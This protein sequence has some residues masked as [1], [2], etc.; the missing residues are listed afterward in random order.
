MRQLIF[1]FCILF[2]GL[3]SGYA[4]KLLHEKKQLAL[5]CSIT[6]LRILLQKTGLIGFLAGSFFLALWVVKLPDVRLSAMPFLCLCALFFGGAL[7]YLAARV[8]H[9]P[10]RQTGALYCC[11]AFTNIGAIGSLICYVFLGE[12]GF[13]L[14][15]VY[16][17]FE[18]LYYFTIGFSTA[19]SFSPDGASSRNLAA[20]IRQVLT[21]P[22]VI[23][24]L[25]A[26]G[27]GT[28]LNMLGVPRPAWCSL[29]TSV[30]V[31]AGTICLLTSIGLAV[32]FSRITQYL[33][34]CTAILAI[35]FLFV[36]MMVT[37]AGYAL[38]L[39]GLMD[40]LPLKVM[41]ICSSMPVAFLALVPPSL[42]DLDLDL[43]NSCWIVST[44]ALLV[45]LPALWILLQLL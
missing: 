27:F 8:F 9:L 4:L 15:P 10:P 16:K 3:G 40:G 36:P 34:E 25:L 30:M 14:V 12:S 20:R 45:T 6:Q 31:P 7:A 33:R 35:K 17:L 26:I 22:F 44:G 42:Y 18:E 11:G 2:F 38:G 29:L 43:A 13:A 28:G 41:L 19:K 37:G 39:G 24:I 5:P 23:S 21:D 1:T 32:Q